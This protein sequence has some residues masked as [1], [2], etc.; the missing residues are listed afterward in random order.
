[1]YAD[2][3][4]MSVEVTDRSLRVN[5]DGNTIGLHFGMLYLSL[6]I[7]EAEL[8]MEKLQAVLS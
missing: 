6:A 7:N 4:N 1:M 3:T 5:P 8:L 2:L